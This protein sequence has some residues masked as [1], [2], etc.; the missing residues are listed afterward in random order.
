MI[1]LIFL[2]CLLANVCAFAQQQDTTDL[3]QLLNLSAETEASDLQKKL[4]QQVGAASKKALASRE[5][6]GIVSVITSEDITRMGAR[7]LMDV[8]RLVP[9]FDFAND[10]N[11]VTGIALRGAWA[12][13]GK[14]LVLLDGQEINDLMYQNVA[15]FNRF[16][17]DLIQ[18]IEIIRGPGSAVYGGT[19]AYGV[20]NIITKG[21]TEKEGITASSLYGQLPNSFGRKNLQLSVIKNIGTDA[22]VDVSFFRGQAIKSDQQYFRQDGSRPL[23]DLTDVTITDTYNAN[24]GFKMKGFSFRGIFEDYKSADPDSSTQFKNYFF[25]VKNEFKVNS[26]FTLT[27]SIYFSSQ[28]PW[29]QGDYDVVAQRIKGGLLGSYDFSRRINLIFG[30]EYFTDRAKVGF[31]PTYFGGSD[32]IDFNLYSVYAQGLFKLRWVNVITGFRYDKHSAFGGAF[33]PRIAL[34]KRFSDLHFKALASGSY[35]AP[36]IANINL[37]SNIKPERSTV[38]EIEAGY[39][40][41]SDMILT[42]NAFQVTTA[43]IITYLA[44]PPEDY[45]NNRKFGTSGIEIT[46]NLKRPTWSFETNFSYYKAGENTAATFSVADNPNAFIGIPQTKLVVIAGYNL[47]SRLSINGTLNSFG[48]R[49]AYP[50]LDSNGDPVLTE[51]NA[52]SLLNF[53]ITHT[54][55]FTKGLTVALGVYDLLDNRPVIPQAYNGGF[56]PLSGRSREFTIRLGYTLPFNSK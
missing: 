23:V 49:F 5:T 51:L 33:V 10:V 36:G 21:T 34:T 40:L 55:I 22:R 1:R 37:N 54:D 24:I 45:E 7:D 38:L 19:A 42:V 30:T 15:F 2:L 4:N 13:E 11:F 41:T 14:V 18:R 47:T 12:F 39:Q 46:Y 6:P 28:R 43:D 56:A 52:Y 8:L 16:P 32:K 27:P 29:I 31:D 3:S 26:K 25:T 20:V 50:T 17:V 9:G 44:G 35:R 53:N 48:K